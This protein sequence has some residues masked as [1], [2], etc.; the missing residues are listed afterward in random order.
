MK[1]S[2][3]FF[4]IF[5]SLF[6]SNI[7]YELSEEKK[8]ELKNLIE[9]QIKSAKL[10]TM[11][12]VIVDEK[13]V[14]YKNIFGE[15]EMKE[16][17]PFIIGSVSK[18]FTALT[19]FILGVDINKTLDQF[20]L[21]EYIKEEDAKKITIRE[22]L[23][24]T[25]GL[26]QFGSR[27][28]YEKGEHHYSNY[29]FALLG[30]IIEK[31]CGKSYH[32]CLKEKIFDPLQMT[33]TQAKKRDDL[34]TSYDNFFGFSIKYTGINKEIGDGFMIPAGFISSTLND[35]GKYL[36]MY[37]KA[38]N[39]DYP[40]FSEHIARMSNISSKIRYNYGYGYGLFIKKKT[41]LTTVYHSGGARSFLCQF[42]IFK[43][44]NFGV[45]IITNTADLFCLYT[46]ETFVENIENFLINDYY[47][48]IDKSVY[49]CTHFYMD[50][51]FIF[52]LSVPLI[53][54]IITIVRKCKKKEYIWFKEVKGKIIFVVELI[55]LIIL[56]VAIIVI[57]YT[58]DPDFTYLIN[59]FRDVQFV[60]FT[61]ASALFLTFIIKLIYVFIYDKYLEHS[62]LSSSQIEGMEISLIGIK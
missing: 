21:K 62:R 7:S 19:L 16:D 4:I 41:G 28:K 9:T 34:I 38:I 60:I 13:D 51:I 55:L 54:L 8:A 17:S 26:Q 22:L 48:T 49:T 15:N 2:S 50:M 61:G 52:S 33:N 42:T 44:R 6:I 18:S 36:Q 20:D 35:M 59:N 25:S 47:D 57:L 37:V 12:I 56:P 31:E 53:Y 3:C 10:H 23:D 11:G 30:K 32:E 58:I 14:L 1:F 29:G 39:G 40:G 24:H 27:I 46:S 5:F 45:Y 43:E